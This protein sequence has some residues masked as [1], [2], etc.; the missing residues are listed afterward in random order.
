MAVIWVPIKKNYIFCK[1]IF[2][3]LFPTFF[4]NLQVFSG[5]SRESSIWIYFIISMFQD[6]RV[7]SGKWYRPACHAGGREFESR[8][9]RHFKRPIAIRQ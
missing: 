7:T 5:K 9:P 3:T 6:K 8:R 2:P 4:P 1:M